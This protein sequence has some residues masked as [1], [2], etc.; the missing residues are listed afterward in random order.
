MKCSVNVCFPKPSHC[1]QDPNLVVIF[2]LASSETGKR[3]SSFSGVSFAPE[4]KSE[5]KHHSLFNNPDC[6]PLSQGPEMPPLP[7]SPKNPSPQAGSQYTPDS[8]R[9]KHILLLRSFMGAAKG[10]R[11]SNPM[12]PR[13]EGNSSCLPVAEAHSQGGSGG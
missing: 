12:Q 8:S 4:T 1:P 2:C 3:H 13:G 5:Y 6:F 11:I 9:L 7:Q 10:H